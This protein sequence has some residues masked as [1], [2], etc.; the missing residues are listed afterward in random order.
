MCSIAYSHFFFLF[1]LFEQLALQ[2]RSCKAYQFVWKTAHGTRL[3]GGE[4]KRQHGHT[5]TGCVK[6][7]LNI[8]GVPSDDCFAIWN[9]TV[10]L[11][12]V[13]W[14]SDKKKKTKK[15]TRQITTGRVINIRYLTVPKHIWLLLNIGSSIKQNKFCFSNNL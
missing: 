13:F 5:W 15:K 10:N 6:G 7:S 12:W 11:K 3:G 4:A 2:N 14:H 1:H 8:Q 9:Q